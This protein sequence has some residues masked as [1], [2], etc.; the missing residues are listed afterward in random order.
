MD[1]GSLLS[2]IVLGSL[3]VGY[4]I[5]GKRQ[6]APIPLVCGLVLM[7][8]PYFVSNAIVMLLLGGIVSAIPWLIR[9]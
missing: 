6:Q 7:I 3:G 2:G 5:Y 9:I 4:F 8:G 1:T